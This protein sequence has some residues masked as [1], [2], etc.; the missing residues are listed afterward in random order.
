M[1]LPKFHIDGHIF[2]ITTVVY[3]RQ[4]VF[5]RPSFIIPLYD[6]LAFYRHKLDIKILGYVFMPDHMHL[7]LWPQQAENI[8]AFMRDFKEFTAK[9]IVRQ[10][11]VEKRDDLL[12]TFRLAGEA[13]GRA[14]HKVW[15]DDFWEV[16]VFTER[17]LRQK[18]NYIHR[19][20][21]RAG[22]VTEPS[23]YPYSSFRNYEIGDESLMEIDRGWM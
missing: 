15:Q 10:A 4:H 13:T 3:G 16:N 22:I 8:T 5:D 6:S 1:S 17:F 19:N 11:K 18:L 21:V 14:I 9:R 2:Y 20:P 7:L 12:N 23:D